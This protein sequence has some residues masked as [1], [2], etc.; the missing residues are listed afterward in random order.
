MASAIDAYSGLFA[1]VCHLSVRHSSVGI[2]CQAVGC[3][4]E[5]K[6]CCAVAGSYNHQEK[7]QNGQKKKLP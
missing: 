6:H 7:K 5:E 2:V 1:I 3:M 4:A